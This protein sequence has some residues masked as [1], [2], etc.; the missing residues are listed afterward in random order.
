MASH[1]CWI[2]Y[3]NARF[4]WHRFIFIF[5]KSTETKMQRKRGCNDCW[6]QGITWLLLICIII[7][8]SQA[9]NAWDAGLLDNYD[10]RARRSESTD[11]GISN[12]KQWSGRICCISCNHVE[13]NH[14]RFLRQTGVHTGT[15]CVKTSRLMLRNSIAR[16]F[17]VETERIV[18]RN[19]SERLFRETERLRIIIDR[20]FYVETE[21]I[22]LQYS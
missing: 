16:R 17:Y 4:M 13:V 9:N 19:V 5:Q 10:L 8:Y 2:N 22:V 15:F 14:Y 11:I 21:R 18:L 6:C 12:K 1:F 3:A 7:I 20:L